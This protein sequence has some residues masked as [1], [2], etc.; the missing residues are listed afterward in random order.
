[1][2]KMRQP[3]APLPRSG[4]SF[5]K[6][7]A[8]KQ[9]TFQRTACGLITRRTNLF[10]R[11]IT[12]PSGE[13]SWEE[14]IILRFYPNQQH[15]RKRNTSVE[16]PYGTVKRWRGANYLLTKGKVEVA[17]ETGLSFLAYNFRR[18]VNLQGIDKLLQII[19][20]G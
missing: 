8:R 14:A 15:L 6:G 7:E 4:R 16:H 17:D 10:F 5:K 2:P 1:M 9:E 11:L 3:M 20:A 13:G 18:A 19:G 12:L